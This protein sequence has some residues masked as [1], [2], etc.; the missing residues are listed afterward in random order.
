MLRALGRYCR[1]RDVE[2]V[3][4]RDLQRVLAPDALGG[5][6]PGSAWRDTLLLAQ[7]FDLVVVRDELVVVAPALKAALAD[8]NVDRFRTAL[9]RLV[10]AP[11][12]NDGLWQVADGRWLS[13]GSREFSRAAAWFLDQPLDRRDG[14]LPDRARRQVPGNHKV[15]ENEEQ[16]RVFVR[17][18]S[19]LGLSTTL[20]G[21][22]IPDPTVAV[23]D[24]L[25]HAFGD[26]DELPA[27]TLR[28]R[29]VAAL[30]VL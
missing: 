23:R 13:S 10:L 30:P 24:E 11:A 14:T 22:P 18:S 16:A 17:W 4:E 7:E 15:I 28:D 20:F 19:S 1:Y 26:E 9:R 29:L 6:G 5:G 25:R 8:D 12:H 2:E 27:L 21:E 3:A